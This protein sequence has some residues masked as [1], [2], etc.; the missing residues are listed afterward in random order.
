[1]RRKNGSNSRFPSENSLNEMNRKAHTRFEKK[2]EEPIPSFAPNMKEEDARSIC[3]M[4]RAKSDI[5]KYCHLHGHVIDKCPTIICKHCRKVGHPIWICPNN[6]NAE[7]RNPLSYVSNEASLSHSERI[8][9]GSLEKMAFVPHEMPAKAPTYEKNEFVQSSVI[10]DPPQLCW[11]PSDPQSSSASR[12]LC[13]DPSDPQSSSAS[14]QLCWDPSD[15]QSSS[16]SRQPL[17]GV[18]IRKVPS[19]VSDSGTKSMYCV[20]EEQEIKKEI[21]DI[22]YY[23]NIIDFKWGDLC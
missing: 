18:P 2:S 10:C 9:G 3:S 5:C 16:A 11:D 19:F 15:P 12:Q 13:W 23:Q 6:P 20:E 7:K 22:R 8:K 4:S 17:E 14:R 21:I 1:M